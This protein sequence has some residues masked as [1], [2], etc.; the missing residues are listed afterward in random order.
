MRTSLLLC[1]VVF[2]DG[3]TT[4][5]RWH[6]SAKHT[7][8]CTDS[9]FELWIKSTSA[10]IIKTA[11]VVTCHLKQLGARW[12]VNDDSLNKMIGTDY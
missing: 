4:N 9:P 5:L 1:V 6:I 10:D 11:F 2:F 8:P 3:N 7:L 12:S